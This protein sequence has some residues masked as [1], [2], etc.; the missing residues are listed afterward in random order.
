MFGVSIL[1]LALLATP[2]LFSRMR[3]GRTATNAREPKALMNTGASYAQMSETEQLAF[4]EDQAQ[5]IS[6]LM[7]D[8]PVKLNQEAV[9]SIKQRVDS[10]TS[11]IGSA[12]VEAGKEDLRTPYARAVPYVPLIAKSF[13]ARKIPIVVGLYLPMVESEYKNCFENS[14]GAKGLFQ[15]MPQTARHYGVSEQEMCDVEKM[16]PAAAHY[17]ADR[18][19]ELGDD[20]ESMTLVLLSYNQGP[21]RV[22]SALREVRGVENYERNFW[23]LFAH[24]DKLDEG[25]RREAGYVPAFFAAAIVGENPQNFGLPGPALSTLAK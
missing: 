25:F 2:F 19:A 6:R 9:N 13:A 18:M 10:Y 14:F 17:I 4:I 16:T 20:S 23:T 21:E 24:R 22:R 3:A 12:S 8:H 11:R 7:G 15:F 5:R 1:V